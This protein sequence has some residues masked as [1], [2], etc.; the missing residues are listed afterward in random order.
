MYTCRILNYSSSSTLDSE[1]STVSDITIATAPTTAIGLT[2]SK[3][4]QL[5]V[6]RYNREDRG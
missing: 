4:I 1:I 6:G 2:T 3:E 5:E